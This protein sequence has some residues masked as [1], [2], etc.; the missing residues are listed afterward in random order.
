MSVNSKLFVYNENQ[1]AIITEQKLTLNWWINAAVIIGAL[2]TF[3]LA[4]IEGYKVFIAPKF[5]A[6][7]EE[8]IKLKKP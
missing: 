6:G 3:A 5:Q 2:S 1:K 8:V 4:G 7:L